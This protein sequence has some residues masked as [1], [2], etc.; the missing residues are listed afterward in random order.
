M[1]TKNKTLTKILLNA[2]LYTFY[3]VFVC[4]IFMNLA[5]PTVEN[6]LVVIIFFFSIGFIFTMFFCSFLI[7][8]EIRNI[9][10]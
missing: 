8:K 1:E 10:K 2:L 4:F 5:N 3:V 9:N 6:G 7:I